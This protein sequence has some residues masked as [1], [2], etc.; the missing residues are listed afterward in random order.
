MKALVTEDIDIIC[1]PD[2]MENRN[3]LLFNTIS[4]FYEY[5][6]GDKV[7]IDTGTT[8]I[9]GEIEGFTNYPVVKLARNPNLIILKTKNSINGE[10]TRRLRRII[11]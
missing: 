8:R 11:D 3:G 5:L 6:E 9:S 2:Y 7:N 10:H 4:G 1:V